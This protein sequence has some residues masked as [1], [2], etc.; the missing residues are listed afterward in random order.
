MES[1]LAIRKPPVRRHRWFER[2]MAI[3]A[4]INFALVL[5]DLSYIPWRDFYLREIPSLI[6]VYD[7]IK[8]IEP[9]RE[10][11]AYLNRVNELEPQVMQTG[12]E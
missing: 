7:P 2:L 1:T 10:T 6:Q 12:I 3:I 4:T 11:Q 9:H 8:G 5:F